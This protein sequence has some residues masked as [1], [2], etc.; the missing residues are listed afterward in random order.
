V[1]GIVAF[2]AYYLRRF[3]DKGNVRKIMAIIALI[4]ACIMTSLA[5]YP[6]ILNLPVHLDPTARLTGWKELGAEVSALYEQMSLNHPVF[7]FSDRY[8]VSSQLA[9]YVR[10]HPVTYC[11]NNGR[12]MNQYDLWPSFDSLIRHHAIFVKTGDVPV[13]EKVAAAFQK[14]EKKVFTAYTKRHARI[15][16]YSIFVCYDFKGVDLERPRTY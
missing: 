4:L 9:F 7:I 12:R 2:T 8:Q 15:R 5:H 16:D 3:F 11:M 13:P 14:V 10:G 1:T 6:Q